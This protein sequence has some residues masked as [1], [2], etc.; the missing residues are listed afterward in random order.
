MEEGGKKKDCFSPRQRETDKGLQM[1]MVAYRY[2]KDNFW[3]F[4]SEVGRSIYDRI[5]Y[6]GR[7]KGKVP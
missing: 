4:C 6:Y 2:E 5:I 1:F 7:T 3:T